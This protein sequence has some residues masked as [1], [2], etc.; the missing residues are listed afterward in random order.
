M[1]ANPEEIVCTADTWILVAFAQTVGVI[2]KLSNLPNV[3]KQTY[4][5]TGEAAPLN[6]DDAVLAFGR[7]DNFEINSGVAIDVYV[8]AVRVNGKI[9]ADL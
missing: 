5:L 6:D 1:A 7:C 4:R 3:Y 8:K 9:R 2:H